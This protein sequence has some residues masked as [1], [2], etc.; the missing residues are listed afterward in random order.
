MG[1]ITAI[2][3][4]RATEN[5]DLIFKHIDAIRN[6]GEPDVVEINMNNFYG[7][8][9]DLYEG[10][11]NKHIHWCGDWEHKKAKDIDFEEIYRKAKNLDHTDLSGD[12]GYY[13]QVYDEAEILKEIDAGNPLINKIWVG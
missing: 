13:Y 2:H 4:F 6:N 10:S 1:R 11:I 5:P 3:L 12:D 8:D 7:I 9:F